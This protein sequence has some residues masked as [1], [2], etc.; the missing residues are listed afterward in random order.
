MTTA[1]QSDDTQQIT[2]HVEGIGHLLSDRLLAIPDYQRSYSWTDDEVRELWDDLIK[3][4]KQQSAEYF[5]GSIVTTKTSSNRDQ[6]IDG[7]QRLATISLLFAAMAAQLRSRADERG[8]EIAA[9][10][11][12]KKNMKTRVVEQRLTLNA[13]DNE[14]FRQ[15]VIGTR[16]NVV[17]KVE[18]HKRLI[19]AYDLL[20]SGIQQLDTTLDSIHWADAVIDVHD[21]VLTRAKVIGVHV[22]NE[23][24]A[25]VI[26]ETL[27]DRG[28][29]LST[30][31]LLKNHL[32]G[33]SQDRLE[34]VKHSWSVASAPF[35]GR[36]GA[37]D[38]D[39]FLRQYWASIRGVTRIK[40]L[41]SEVRSHIDSP[42]SAV[43][44]AASL[45]SSSV[46][47]VSMFDR[48][49]EFWK[50][51]PLKTR[52]AIETLAALKIE[53][54]RPLLLAAMRRFEAEEV[55]SLLAM[56]VSW[57]VRWFVVRGWWWWRWGHGAVI[58]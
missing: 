17:P 1:T 44:F 15:L 26:F 14:L 28:L 21:Y 29:N 8:E 9:E 39:T 46:L 12:G 34:E 31:D 40:A 58:C 3:A 42:Q 7:Q 54:C 49:A 27:N 24:R 22:N 32:F 18:S 25:F 4:V 38:I 5:L 2:T 51:Y 57:N 48:D 13:E 23:N 10:M 55:S 11:L 20:D 19:A 37:G 52:A 16:S 53:Q 35:G 45:S 36:E 33:M 30:G 6:V 47:W 50:L 56:L 43:D 41:F